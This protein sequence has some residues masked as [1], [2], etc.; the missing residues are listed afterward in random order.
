MKR[1]SLLLSL[2]FLLGCTLACGQGNIGIK[3]GYGWVQA[4]NGDIPGSQFLLGGQKKFSKRAGVDVLL[5]GTH[6]ER[7]SDY[8]GLYIYE[9]SNGV[10]LE[11]L[12]DLFINVGRFSFYPSVGPVL[13][14]AH[15]IQ[16]QNVGIWYGQS[17]IV[18]YEYDLKDEKGFQMG[19]AIAL[20][21]D[22]RVYKGFSLGV[23]GSFQK[24]LNGQVLPF[25]G[26]VIKNDRWNF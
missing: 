7:Q 11:A 14:Y 19:Y 17:G 20:N 23:R 5:A 12:F 10:A 2:I 9:Q 25:M 13:R 24:Y 21:L 18:D 15:E 6:I 26:V 8:G 4:G 3:L 16:A 1:Y 22:G